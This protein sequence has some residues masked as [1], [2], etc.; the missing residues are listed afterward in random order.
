MKL[1]VIHFQMVRITFTNH[2]LPFICNRGVAIK[3]YTG[4]TVC[5]CPPSFYGLQCEYYSDR[6]TVLT[7]LHFDDY[8]SSLNIIKVLTTFLFEDEIIDYYE[9]HVDPQRQIDHNYVK[10]QI[11]FV[12]PRL[13][14]FVQMKKNN[15]SGTQLYSV[16]FEAFN[17]HLNETI[18]IIGVWKYSIY[19]DNLPSFRLSKILRFPSSSVN[20]PCLNHS[21]TSKWNLSKDN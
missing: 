4:H 18:Q 14:Q 17:L 1:F 11:Y 8:L 16:R 13:K 2:Y 9:F 7:H 21:C 20:D 19:F 10:Q 6:I 5:F 3:Y 15:R 12:Y